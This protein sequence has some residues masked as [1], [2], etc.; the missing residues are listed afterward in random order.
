MIHPFVL[1]EIACGT[2][3]QRAHTLGDLASLQVVQQLGLQELMDFIA[4][5]ALFGLGCGFVDLQL[6]ASTLITPGVE[7][8]TTDKRLSALAQRFGVL[9][10][11]ARH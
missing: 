11:P 10:Q 9:H 8:W 4:R 3:P 5:E 1:G 2:P 6:L 7:L